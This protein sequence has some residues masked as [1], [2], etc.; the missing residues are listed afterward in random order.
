MDPF[1]LATVNNQ[2][3]LAQQRHVAGDLRLRLCGRGAEIADAQFSRFAEQHDDGEP[4]FVRESFEELER[5][6]HSAILNVF[7]YMH[8]IIYV[9]DEGEKSKIAGRIEK[10]P[11]GL[12]KVKTVLW[13]AR[14]IPDSHVK[15]TV[16]LERFL[17][18]CLRSTL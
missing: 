3:G 9:C 14:T 17:F 5:V 2:P 8:Q 12:V 4:R 15:E 1:P 6:E 18:I 7:C 13:L 10:A 11:G 16:P